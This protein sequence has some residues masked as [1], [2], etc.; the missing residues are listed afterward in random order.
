VA[1]DVYSIRMIGEASLD[2]S[3][4][5]IGP[6]VPD[7]LVYVV[8]DID[9]WELTGAGSTGLEIT[10][11][12]G[13]PLLFWQGGT[14]VPTRLFAWRGRQVYGEGEQVGAIVTGGQWSLQ[15]SGYQLTLP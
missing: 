4:G 11:A 15:V 13:G 14:T 9:A 1:R 6:V 8:R 12:L 7:G 10:N 2:S 3:S 5:L